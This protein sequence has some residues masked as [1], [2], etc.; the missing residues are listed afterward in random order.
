MHIKVKGCSD[1]DLRPPVIR[2]PN[3][4]QAFFS[5]QASAEARCQQNL[6]P[7]IQFPACCIYDDDEFSFKEGQQGKSARPYRNV[8]R[9]E[10]MICYVN[11]VRY[12]N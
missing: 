10:E 9:T 2:F 6:Y 1:K 12:C 7:Y 3:M 5:L 4:T 8:I 11:F